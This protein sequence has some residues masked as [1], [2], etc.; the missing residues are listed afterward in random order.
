MADLSP[1]AGPG[2]AKTAGEPVPL[3]F[4]TSTRESVELTVHFD[5]DEPWPPDSSFRLRQA[6][7]TGPWTGADPRG[8][9]QLLQK[10]IASRTGRRV[11][12]TPYD[13]LDREIAVGVQL[14]RNCAAAQRPYPAELAR[15]VGYDVDAVEPFA[16]YLPY[17]GEPVSAFAG[18]LMMRDQ[19]AFEVGLFRAL[20]YLEAFGVTHRAIG[21]ETVRWDPVAGRAQIVD[22]SRA[23]LA[24]RALASAHRSPW[25]HN[26]DATSCDPRADVWSAGALVYYAISGRQPG[27]GDPSADPVME[28]SALR[29][30]SPR[31][32]ADR[33]E[34]RPS[35]AEVLA[36]LNEPEPWPVPQFDPTEE[37]ELFERGAEDF[38]RVF[39]PRHPPSPPWPPQPPAQAPG[40]ANNGA[41]PNQQPSTP[42]PA[43]A[44]PWGRQARRGR[45][46][47]P[48]GFIAFALSC[49]ALIPAVVPSRS[50]EP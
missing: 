40:S 45:R 2:A 14:L 39:P 18:R 44:A 26:S 29:G 20:R 23:A 15:L 24:G 3:V 28:S 6:R 5:P 25:L 50:R 46:L 31:I 35:A 47:W 11:D 8:T 1:D 36:A 10:R 4:A 38:D 9:T 16:L 33:A 30:L 41:R 32:L 19:R 13:T 27:D 42:P 17:R 43:A 48:F 12:W 7:L 21:P 34:L 37:D 49:A 22:F